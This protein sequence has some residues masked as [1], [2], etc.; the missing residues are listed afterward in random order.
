MPERSRSRAELPEESLDQ[1]GS[2][3]QGHVSIE[4]LSAYHRRSLASEEAAQVRS[5][6][7]HC[8]A[9]RSLL[10]DLAQFLDDEQGP[11]HMTPEDVEEARRQLETRARATAR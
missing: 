1:T 2:G 9:C 5:H 8:R 11:G 3:S 6:V 4:V 7:V 10:L